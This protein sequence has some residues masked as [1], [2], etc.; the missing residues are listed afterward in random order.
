[1]R[2]QPLNSF[3]HLAPNLGSRK[4]EITGWRRRGSSQLDVGE[5]RGK[6]FVAGYR[7]KDNDYIH[8]EKKKRKVRGLG[9][10]LMVR[11]VEAPE[12]APVLGIPSKEY[13]RKYY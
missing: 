10:L 12:Y 2:A 9:E 1:M 6:T 5:L 4:I 7:S 3:G 13:A 8:E 11:D